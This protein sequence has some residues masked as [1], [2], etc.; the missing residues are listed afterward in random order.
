MRSSAPPPATDLLPLLAV[1]SA[2]FHRGESRCALAVEGEV[3]S[4]RGDISAKLQIYG[5]HCVALRSGEQRL[6]LSGHEALALRVRGDGRRYLLWL[7]TGE[8]FSE[9]AYEADFETHPDA[10]RDL[11]LPFSAL[12]AT[13][14]WRVLPG[15]PPFDPAAVTEI[16]LTT[17][18]QEGPFSLEIAALAAQG[19]AGSRHLAPGSVGEAW[20]RLLEERLFP[21]AL[22]AARLRPETTPEAV[23]AGAGERRR[24][25]RI[26]CYEESAELRTEDLLAVRAALTAARHTGDLRSHRAGQAIVYL[27]MEAAYELAV[28]ADVVVD[29][30]CEGSAQSNYLEREAVAEEELAR[31]QALDGPV[32]AALREAGLALD[33]G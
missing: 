25:R 17:Y 5:G 12:E 14:D 28:A 26:P 13:T 24:E 11:V 8:T 9:V 18:W 6:D 27:A 29:T 30:S 7:R 32:S 33:E 23:F 4:F 19:T 2:V 21:L 22:R 3:V 31:F 15:H 1:G 16:G 20:A 10:W